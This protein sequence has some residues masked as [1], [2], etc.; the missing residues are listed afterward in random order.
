MAL[1]RTYPAQ[2]RMIPRGPDMM[3]IVWTD[4]R[5]IA[6][7]MCFGCK[8]LL[9]L[10]GDL[11][12]RR[13]AVRFEGGAE[14]ERIA[15]DI[16]RREGAS[17]EDLLD[18]LPQVLRERFDLDLEF[19][20]TAEPSPTLVL[21]G[22]VGV[23]PPHDVAGDLGVLHVFTDRRNEPGVGGGG[24]VSTRQ[25]AK[26]LS[27]HLQMPVVDETNGADGEPFLVRLHDSAYE[28]QRLDLLIRSQQVSGSSPLAGSR[29]SPLFAYVYRLPP[30]AT[31]A[32]CARAGCI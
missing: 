20:M 13:G 15:A 4:D 9:D 11:G 26:F 12:V 1:Y 30:R 10:L 25:M 32:A 6:G 29:V 3:T 2:A 5:P 28:T 17:R 14:D 24:L 31:F 27:G 18:E 16:V 19:R 8:R 23:L 7:N 22:A 21:R